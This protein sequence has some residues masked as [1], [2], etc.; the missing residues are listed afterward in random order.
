LNQNL[1]F[2]KNQAELNKDPRGC[3]KTFPEV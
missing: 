3:E 1:D 2:I